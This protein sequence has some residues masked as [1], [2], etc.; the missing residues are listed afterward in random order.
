MKLITGEQGGQEWFILRLFRFTSSTS[1]AI[2][3]MGRTLVQSG[4]DGIV[5]EYEQSLKDISQLVGVRKRLPSDS[6]V[7]ADVVNYK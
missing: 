1:A 4:L 6:S 2:L 7:K 3:R 5:S